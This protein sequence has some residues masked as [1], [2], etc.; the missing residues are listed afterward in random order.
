MC[1]YSIHIY[2]YTHKKYMSRY[3]YT[4]YKHTH[5][6]SILLCGCPDKQFLNASSNFLLGWIFHWHPC[7]HMP[8]W[9]A[10]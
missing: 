7:C 2:V 5:T 1:I 3:I 8:L 9:S 6:H 4:Y 10:L